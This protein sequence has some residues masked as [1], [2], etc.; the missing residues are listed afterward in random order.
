M[1]SH[2]T[3]ELSLIHKQT[4]KE[5]NALLIQLANEF[6]SSHEGLDTNTTNEAIL[7]DAIHAVTGLGVS[8]EDEEVVLNITN[9]LQGGE[10]NPK[11]T[12]RVIFIVSLIP[13]EILV[14]IASHL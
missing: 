7:H 12:E 6:Q 4:T 14:A 3:K 13:S 11:L 2:S 1:V 5:M 8:L 10:T 9:Y